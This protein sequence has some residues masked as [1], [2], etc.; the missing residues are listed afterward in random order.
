MKIGVVDLSASKA[1]VIPLAEEQV[2]THLGG[3]AMNSAILAGYETDALVFGTG[4]LTGSFAPAS[5]LMIATFPSPV[6][7]S[8][9][10]VPLML[11]TGPDMKFS[12][13]DF[14]VVK[15]T[16]PEPSV[17]HVNHGKI[18]IIPAGNLQHL[19]VPEAIRELKKTAPPFQSAIITG[20]AAD[21]GCSYA[22]VS[23]GTNGSLDK[24]GLATLM[25]AKNLKG[26][27]FGGGGGL[28]FNRDNPDQGKELEGIISTDKNFKRRGFYSL[29]KQFGRRERRGK[30]AQGREK[31]GHGL[32]SLPFAL[33]DPCEILVA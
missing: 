25:A 28:A 1:E 29:L 24:A 6:F 21:R 27:M 4:P 26:I 17:L 32:L 22:S 18:R 7:D 23:I 9:C 12:G 3:A 11:R 2:G 15:G 8:I 20:P 31:K 14:L 10:H 30:I 13:V 5:P 19:P 33:H 16:A